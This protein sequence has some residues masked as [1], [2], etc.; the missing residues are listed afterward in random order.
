MAK[1]KKPAASTTPSSPSAAPAWLHDGLPLPRLIVLDLDY[2]LWPFY[3]DIHIAPPIRPVPN[4]H[5]PTLADRNGEHFALYP[6][7]PHILRLL[8]SLPPAR[9]RLAVASKSPVGDLCRDVLKQLRLPPPLGD[10]GGGADKGVKRAID[11]FDAGLEIYEGSKIRHFEV[12]AKRTGIPYGQM[13]FFDDERPNLEVES[14]G[15]TMRLVRD[16]LT[17][18]ELEKGIEQWRVNQ[19]VA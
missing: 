5:P 7:A 18:E 3:S 19:G 6:D 8:S 11:A 16:G 9:L 4:A 17:W 12:L 15:V 14:L 10:A 13:L 2:T 1:S